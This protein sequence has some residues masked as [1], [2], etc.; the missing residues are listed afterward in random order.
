MCLLWNQKRIENQQQQGYYFILIKNL[1]WLSIWIKG[2]KKYFT[3]MYKHERFF[4]VYGKYNFL[5]LI[6]YEL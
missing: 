3:D 1:A 4:I 6:T 5:I 2:I